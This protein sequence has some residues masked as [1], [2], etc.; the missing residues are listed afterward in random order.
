MSEDHALFMM[1]LAPVLDRI[2]K[3]AAPTVVSP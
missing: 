3:T 1:Y 2:E